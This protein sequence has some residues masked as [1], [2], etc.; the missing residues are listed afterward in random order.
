MERREAG[1]ALEMQSAASVIRPGPTGAP[2]LPGSL[3]MARRVSDVNLLRLLS[4][5]SVTPVYSMAR[6]LIRSPYCVASRASA[7]SSNFGP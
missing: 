1:E 3:R 6:L 2:G 7:A 4:P 5:A